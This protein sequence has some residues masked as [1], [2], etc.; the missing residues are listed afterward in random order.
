MKSTGTAMAKCCRGNETS[1]QR[2]SNSLSFIAAWLSYS[3]ME[4]SD[5]QVTEQESAEWCDM[6]DRE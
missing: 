4:G 3:T 2:I 1:I 6:N 5:G